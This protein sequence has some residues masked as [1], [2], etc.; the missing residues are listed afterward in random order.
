MC[1][2]P[3]RKLVKERTAPPGIE[4]VVV[5]VKPGGVRQNLGL[6]IA[7]HFERSMKL[8]LL[9]KR[10]IQP[11]RAELERFLSW[12]HPSTRKTGFKLVEKNQDKLDAIER[13]FGT[14]E[15]LGVAW[16]IRE[17]N[18]EH[19]TSGPM[20]AMV[21][22][23]EEALKRGKAIKYAIRKIY[24]TEGITRDEAYLQG[25]CDDNGLHCST[26]LEELACDEAWLESIPDAYAADE[27]EVRGLR[28]AA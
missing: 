16:Q 15:P 22:E 14:T 10:V 27:L 21:F 24:C 18:I 3:A 23:G 9:Y 19:L 8:K 28:A 5:L 11:T 25:K 13:T 17:R 1:L 12:D 20:I 7:R 4:R 6:I 26:S 2:E